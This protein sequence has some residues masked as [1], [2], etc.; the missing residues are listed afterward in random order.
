M[1]LDVFNVSCGSKCQELQISLLLFFLSLFLTLSSLS[2]P[3]QRE[4]V[5]C[6]SS[7]VTHCYYTGVLLLWW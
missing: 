5:S 1:R 3:S 2:T 7:P 4:S 6:S